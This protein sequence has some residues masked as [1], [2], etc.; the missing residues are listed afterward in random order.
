MDAD[1]V[2]VGG[3]A[4]GCVVARRT[5][6][7]TGARVLLLEAGQICVLKLPPDLRDGWRLPTLPDWGFEA[8][9]KGGN[10]TKLRRGRLLGGT[11][12]LTRFAVRGAAADFD[13]WA[14]RGN[15]G[16][17]FQEVLPVFRRLEADADFGGDPWHGD[18]GPMPITRYPDLPR[19]PIHVATVELL[20]TLGHPRVAD[21][22]R[23]DAVGVG[24]MPMSTRD[25][26]RITTA[27]AYL[28]LDPAL[29]NLEIRTDTSVS[30]IVL[31]GGRATGVR[32]GDGTVIHADE[33]I[34]SAGTYGSPTILLRSGIGPPD[35]LR[36]VGIDC[37]VELPGVGSNL[38][39]HPGVDFDSGWEGAAVDGPI[40]HS[41]ATYHSSMTPTAGA[42]DLMFWLSDPAGA[43][44][45]F[46]LDPILL[47]PASRGTVRLRS[48]DSDDPPR[49]TLPNV[50][51]AEDL[52]RLAEA[53]QR[54]VELA[55]QPMF[56]R[57]ASRTPTRPSTLQERRDYVIANAYSIPHVVGT[58]R[59]GPSPEDGDVVDSRG[60]V[61]GVDALRVIDA[62]IIP[63]PPSGF[64]HIITIMI[65]ERLT[66]G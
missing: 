57:L 41:I 3:G 38:A 25:G 35:H 1:I 53:L 34:V 49:I 55:L 64:P 56:R 2:V 13:D 19:S 18:R 60:R 45:A 20:E 43:E 65:A 16:W 27:D 39:D 15:P 12:W 31:E 36:E 22:N 28:P 17:T 26:R 59:M 23:P 33:V 21:H 46:Y 11:S 24:P 9:A 42:P 47:K 14:T 62:S 48:A 29:G 7:S 8:E 54:A 51:Q 44:P 61:H 5:A 58:C 50:G 40:L 30:R 66:A 32:S 4:A 10:P 52:E 6:E 37:Q 63:E